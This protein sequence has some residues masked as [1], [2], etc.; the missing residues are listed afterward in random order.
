MKRLFITVV[1]LCIGFVS[2]AQHDGH[3]LPHKKNKTNAARTVTPKVIYSCPMHPEVQ[4]S[5]PGSCPKCGM[6]LEKKTIRVAAPKKTTSKQPAK[7]S[8]KTAVK[9][10]AK[11]ET[12]KKP[13]LA[14][15]DRRTD[16]A[17]V[18][19]AHRNHQPAKENS[20]TSKPATKVVY[21]C[22]MHPE[23]QQDQPGKC[24]K[25]GMTL[26]RKTVAANPPGQPAAAQASQ[27]KIVY[28][29]VMHPEVQMDKPGTCPK[30]G[31][32][33]VKKTV[34]VGGNAQQDTTG[35]TTHDR[36]G[37]MPDESPGSVNLSAGRTVVYHLYVR[38]T[39]VNYTGKQKRAVAINGS[40]P[41]PTL[42]F[43][44]GD[45]ADP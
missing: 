12:E 6:A 41:A 38:D 18:A 29:C 11:K 7:T 21:T 23:V 2:L 14:D 16:N 17:A 27:T 30:C 13:G 43:T 36:M 4:R 40:I 10:P 35:Q 15:K 39:I 33:L 26:V 31:M 32:T 8:A 42:T 37:T 28:T 9:P 3:N 24:P 34:T 25:C 20:D 1:V 45:T 5:K 19:D 44:E 22:V